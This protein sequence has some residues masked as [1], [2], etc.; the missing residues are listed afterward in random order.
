MKQDSPRDSHGDTLDEMTILDVFIKTIFEPQSPFSVA[1]QRIHDALR[2]SRRDLTRA[3]VFDLGDHLKDLS[4][5]RLKSTILG[6][7][8]TLNRA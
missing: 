7:K 4:T 5:D 3:S 2:S 8:Q 1:E 6:I